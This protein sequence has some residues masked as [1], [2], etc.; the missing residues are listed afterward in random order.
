MINLKDIDLNADGVADADLNRD[1]TVTQEEINLYRKHIVNYFDTQLGNDI[2]NLAEEDKKRF[3]AMTE[4]YSDV[5]VKLFHKGIPIFEY[6]A[7][8][9]EMYSAKLD[10]HEGIDWNHKCEIVKQYK[11]WQESKK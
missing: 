6:A 5:L 10:P 7:Y 1:G 11:E 2:L 8:G 9:D 4:E 3:F